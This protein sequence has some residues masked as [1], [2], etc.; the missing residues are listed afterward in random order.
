[1]GD[2]NRRG[3]KPRGV[4]PPSRQW[5]RGLPK[6]YFSVLSGAVIALALIAQAGR[7]GETFVVEAILLLSI[8]GFV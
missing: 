3:D 6:I 1:V 7:F 8:V 4:K 5:S 2:H